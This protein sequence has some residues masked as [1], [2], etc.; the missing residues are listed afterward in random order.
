MLGIG[1]LAF[2]SS[3]IFIVTNG[4]K[5]RR[6]RITGGRLLIDVIF[7][8]YLLCVLQVTIFPIPFQKEFLRDYLSSLGSEPRWHYNFIPLMSI[9]DAVK[10]IIAF[11]NYGLEFKNIGGNIVLLTPLGIYVHFIKRNLVFKKVLFIGFALSAII[12]LLQFL[13]SLWLGYSYRSFD[14]DDLILNTSGFLI[15][16]KSFSL[17]KK[18]LSNERFISYDKYHS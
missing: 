3:L 10:N 11:Q 12:E 17:I 6:K 18:E 8:I 14:V 7:F 16:Y 2:V 4:I 1:P 13:I 9:V 15:G 5:F